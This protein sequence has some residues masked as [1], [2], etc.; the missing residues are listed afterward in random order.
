LSFLIGTESIAVDALR[1]DP[2]EQR[3]R[4]PYAWAGVAM[5]RDWQAARDLVDWM[6]EG[7]PFAP[8]DAALW[9][10]L[11]AAHAGNSWALDEALAALDNTPAL[12]DLVIRGLHRQHRA[13]EIESVVRTVAK[14]ISLSPMFVDWILADSLLETDDQLEEAAKRLGELANDKTPVIYR[15][16]M[17][18]NRGVALHRLGRTAEA[19]QCWLEAVA[20]NSKL[21]VSWEM[22]RSTS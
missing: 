2:R 19:Q 12:L 3:V 20:L 9:A 16:Q 18:H 10:G 11:C 14:R 7:D 1:N 6:R 21:E 8:R 5:R 17:L 15:A 13:A 22:L 4:R